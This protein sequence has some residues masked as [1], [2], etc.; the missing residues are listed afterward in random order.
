VTDDLIDE[1]VGGWARERPDLPTRAVP[2]TS[3]V[4]RLA[5]DLHTR[6][7]NAL[8]DAGID[9]ATLD[10]LANLRRL[11][12][13]F[14]A[15]P[16]E[17]AR[18]CGVTPAAITLRIR[19]AHDSGWVERSTAPGDGRRAVVRLTDEGVAAADKY[20]AHVLHHDDRLFATVSDRDLAELERLLRLVCDQVARD[21][22]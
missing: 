21:D 22:A 7:T 1:I 10:L 5:R 18:K 3:L 11:G 12:Q 17:L 20:A 19:R 9:S 16:T 4:W 14:E 13:P 15:A 6:R 2:V 8:R